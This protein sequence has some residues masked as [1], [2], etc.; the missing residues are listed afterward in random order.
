[1][2]AAILSLCTLLLAACATALNG[3]T[4]RNVQYYSL[5]S[6]ELLRYAAEGRDMP[7]RLISN[8]SDAEI[9]GQT[10]MVEQALHDI[11]WLP[12][13]R[14]TA[15]PDGSER[16]NF[17]IAV[18]IDA[19][20]QVDD[21]AC[22]SGDVDRETLGPIDGKSHVVI[23]FCNDD[24]PISSARGVVA[25]ITTPT[26]PQL[27]IATTAAANKAFPRVDPNRPNR[28]VPEFLVP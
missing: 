21:R 8:G 18:V 28:S 23:T 27:G 7:L 9:A 5:Y 6:P 25:A 4:V 22:C 26:A 16:G 20:V 15:T 10:A 24:R 13:G 3:V 17:H 14:L 11:P 12:F 1:M 2:R 19:P